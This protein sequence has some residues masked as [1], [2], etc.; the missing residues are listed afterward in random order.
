MPHLADFPMSDEEFEQLKKTVLLSEEDVRYLRLAGE[1]LR[2][3]IDDVLDLWYSW[4]GSNPHL[5]YYFGDKKTGRPI[6][7]YLEAS[8]RGSGSGS[9]TSARGTT[10]GTG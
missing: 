1:V 8:G 7:E 2:D 10:T 4:V 3:Q 9:G 5:V 6:P